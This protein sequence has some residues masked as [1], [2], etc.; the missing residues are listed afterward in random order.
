MSPEEAPPH[1]GRPPP[2]PPLL[3]SQ[4]RALGSR[5]ERGTLPPPAL[6]LPPGG[7]GLQRRGGARPAAPANQ[8]G[9]RLLLGWEG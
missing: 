5:W 8:A 4:R 9:A 2:S 6:P 1:T 7:A 3:A